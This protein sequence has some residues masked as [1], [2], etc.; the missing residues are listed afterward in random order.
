[1]ALNIRLQRRG[2]RNRPVHKIATAESTSRRDGKVIEVIG[3]SDPD[4]GGKAPELALFLDRR[5]Y[6]IDVGA[7]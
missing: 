4:A 3:N 5:D 7:N 2:N 6:W 1:M